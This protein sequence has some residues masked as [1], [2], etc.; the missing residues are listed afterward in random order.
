MGHLARDP[1]HRR[2]YASYSVKAGHS[3][4]QTCAATVPN[5]DNRAGVSKGSV[6]GGNYCATAQFTHGS[7]LDG[8]IRREGDNVVSLN[9]PHSSKYS[10]VVFGSD[11]C[12]GAFVEECFE[13]NAR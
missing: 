5:S 4:A 2:E 10:A 13:S 12:E 3:F 7:T 8:G 6:V 11:G 9:P 1:R